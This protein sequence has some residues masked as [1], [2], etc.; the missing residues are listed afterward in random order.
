MRLREALSIAKRPHRLLVVWALLFVVPAHACGGPP[1]D[2]AGHVAYVYD[3]DTVRL[4]DGRRIR[5]IG[6]DTPEISHGGRPA[7]PFSL[8]A[9][10]FVVDLLSESGGRV[11][12]KYGPERHDH[13]QRTLAHLYL[14][15]GRNIEAEILRRGLGTALV[16]APNATQATCYRALEAGADRAGRGIWSLRRYHWVRSGDVPPDRRGFARVYGRVEHIGRGGHSL[17]LGLAG[18]LGVRVP[19]SA[20]HYFRGVDLE[21]LHGRT[22]GVRGWLYRRKGELRM[23]LH[24]PID[25]TTSSPVG[26]ARIR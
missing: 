8:A 18:G 26:A 25:L 13:Y 9:R 7:E 5:F 22:I 19:E 4:D 14:P 10:R 24:H 2:A 16:V 15:D 11:R 20:L 6:V 12:L 23:T 1:Y 3:G 17:W 21:A